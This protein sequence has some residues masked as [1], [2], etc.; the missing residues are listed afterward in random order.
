[1]RVLLVTNDYPPKPGG[2]QQ[3]LG[4][5]V[6]HAESEFRVL[7]PAHPGA[8]DESRIV[9]GHSRWMLPTRR[10][11]AWIEEHIAAYEPDVIVF[12]APAPLAQLGPPISKRAGVPYV[13][14]AHGAEVTLPG[15]VPGLRQILGGTFRQSAAVLTVSEYTAR[16]VRAMGGTNV[17]VLGAGVNLDA[18]TP[19]DRGN[20]ETITLVCV[21]RFVPRK[22]HLRVIKAAEKL[23][24]AGVPI[25]VLIVGSGRLERRIRSASAAATVPVRLEVDVAWDRLAS[26]YGEG[27]IFVMPA[28]S[29]WFGLEVEGLG[30]VYLEAAATG[31]P[32]IVGRSGG[33]PETVVPGETG[34]I[35]ESVGEIVEAV[36]LIGSARQHLGAAGRTRVEAHFSWRAV[37]ERFDR[38]MNT[39][40]R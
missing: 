20:A 39:V 25:E 16:K 37:G 10:T 28:R 4:N 23:S 11:R 5:I 35:A 24:A 13:V 26:L 8:P 33:A 3:Y 32:I 9:R 7:A 38:S 31:L 29:R 1:M 21:S 22:G 14:I 12:G 2:I 17:G 15:A 34:Y 40:A 27:D 19:F 30:I 6:A 36:Q 18:F